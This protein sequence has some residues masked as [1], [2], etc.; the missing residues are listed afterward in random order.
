MSTGLRKLIRRGVEQGQ[1][2]VRQALR[3]ILQRMDATKAIPP[4]QVQGLNGEQ[5]AAELMQH[6]GLASAPLTGAEVIVLPIGGNS[7][8]GVV[9][10][11]I[12]KRYRVELKPGEVALH[13]DEGDYVHL[14]RGRLIEVATETLVFKA[15]NKVRFETPLVE[16]SQDITADGDVSD[17]V[18]SMREDRDIYNQHT[19]P[20][21]G[22]VTKV[23][24]QQQ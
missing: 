20:E 3:G 7:A 14:K 23:T 6:Y 12:D 11:S 10:A 24:D 15:S 16:A 13:T 4:A 22:A 9:I 17:K 19:H 8:H 18:R 2:R 5:L 1:Q 21:T